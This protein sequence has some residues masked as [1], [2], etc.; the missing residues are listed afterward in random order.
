MYRYGLRPD[1][2]SVVGIKYVFC[3][4][5]HAV[6]NRFFWNRFAV[7]VL[8]DVTEHVIARA[9]HVQAPVRIDKMLFFVS[10]HDSFKI[11]MPLFAARYCSA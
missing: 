4:Q 7:H 8:H 1:M 10:V 11:R 5:R 2:F 3:I 6:K 9:P